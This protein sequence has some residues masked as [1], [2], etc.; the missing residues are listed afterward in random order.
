MG[1]LLDG[2]EVEG[3]ECMKMMMIKTK[4]IIDSVI[5]LDLENLWKLMI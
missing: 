4:D 1:L 5:R 2:K 3:G